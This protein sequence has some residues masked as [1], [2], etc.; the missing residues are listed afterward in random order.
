L[1][2]IMLTVSVAGSGCKQ[3]RGSRYEC[4]CPFLTDHDDSSAQAVEVCASSKDKAE[5]TARGCAQS[6]APAPV[7]S[8]VCQPAAAAAKSSCP[9]GDC[10]VREDKP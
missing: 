8:C 5:E 6:A 7:E 1:V 10:R 9:V 4:R 3:E 2:L